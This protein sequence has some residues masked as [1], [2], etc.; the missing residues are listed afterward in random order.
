VGYHVHERRSLSKSKAKEGSKGSGFLGSIR[1]RGHPAC[2]MYRRTLV[3]GISSVGKIAGCRAGYVIGG[4][5]GPARQ[6]QAGLALP[7]ST[8]RQRLTQ[9]QHGRYHQQQVNSE[10]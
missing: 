2:N 8:L 10:V 4:A 9:E 5:C 6:V 3:E 1:R 7:V